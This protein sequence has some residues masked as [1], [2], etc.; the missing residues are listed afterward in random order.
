MS[1]ARKYR[2]SLIVANQYISQMTEQIRDAVFGNVGNLVSFRVGATDAEY[3]EKEFAPIFTKDDL[4][5]IP[6]INCYIKMLIN[7][8]VSKPF[9][10]NTYFEID[11]R[12]PKY[13]GMKD[14]IIKWTRANYTKP[15]DQV[16]K[17]IDQ[18]SKSMTV[19][20]PQYN[21]DTRPPLTI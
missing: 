10:M 15:L 21:V 3:L 11:K 7:G 13:N 17:E 18:R 4:I 6:N 12:Y 8:K 20:G 5:S 16:L 14:F 19:Q 1:E 9:S 2:L